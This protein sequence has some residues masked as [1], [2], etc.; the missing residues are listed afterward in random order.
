MSLDSL[1]LMLKGSAKSGNFGHAGRPGKHGGSAPGGG[2]SSSGDKKP[3]LGVQGSKKVEEKSPEP[4]KEVEK[5]REAKEDNLL[6]LYKDFDKGCV[7]AKDPGCTALNTY[8]GEAFEDINSNLRFGE[9]LSKKH[10][11]IVNNIDNAMNDAPRTEE[12]MIVYRSMAPGI[13]N[14]LIQEGSQFQDRAFVST[15]IDSSATPGPANVEIRIPK[16]SKG[17]YVAGLSDYENEKEFLLPRNAKFNVVKK[18]NGG[19]VLEFI[20]DD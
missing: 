9:S 4:K 19:A 7:K 6:D 11:K 12:S 17:I 18:S 2:Y 16:G 15:S 13:V 1:L 20:G 3:R 10:Q 8:T 14:S 5:F